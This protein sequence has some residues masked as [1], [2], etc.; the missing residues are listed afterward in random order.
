[1][2]LRRIGPLLTVLGFIVASWL[3]GASPAAAQYAQ[4][5]TGRFTTTPI[6]FDLGGGVIGTVSFTGATAGSSGLQTPTV[7]GANLVSNF[8][9]IQPGTTAFFSFNYPLSHLDLNWGPGNTVTRTDNFIF[10]TAQASNIPL[11]LTSNL[12]NRSGA[13]SGTGL[14]IVSFSL[15]STSAS[16]IKLGVLTSTAPVPAPMSPVGAT[17]L[18]NVVAIGM[19]M[20]YRRRK[21][22]GGVN[23]PGRGEAI[24]AAA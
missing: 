9:L 8:I 22:R 18:G 1:M 3:L 2:S 6:T 24:I 23:L 13:F 15:S 19:I 10:N 14:D 20:L 4:F 5:Q 21:S 11:P 16:P 17:L 7:S 12:A